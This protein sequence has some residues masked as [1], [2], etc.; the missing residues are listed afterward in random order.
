[1]PKYQAFCCNNC[2]F[3][4]KKDNCSKCGKWTQN[5]RIPAFLCNNCG[6]GN[7]KDTIFFL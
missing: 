2:S 5:N 3:G 4:N 6:F 1:M 7:K